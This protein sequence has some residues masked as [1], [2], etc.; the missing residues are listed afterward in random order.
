V[1]LIGKTGRSWSMVI[2]GPIV[3]QMLTVGI[4]YALFV[5]MDDSITMA[6]CAVITAIAGVAGALPITFK[7]IG[8][9]EAAIVA[10]A[11][12]LG[13][14]PNQ[15]LVVAVL[16]RL[17]SLLVGA[18]C[19]G[20]YAAETPAAAVAARTAAVAEPIQELPVPLTI[21]P[22]RVMQ[23]QRSWLSTEILEFTH[24]AII[25]WEMDGAGILYWN[26]AAEQLYGYRREE[27]FGKTT[28]TLLKT[29]IAGGIK[30]LESKIA[31]YGVWVGEL[32][33]VRRDGAQVQVQG[34]L[35]LMSQRG[36]K[37]LVLEVNRDITDLTNAEIAQRSA[38]A[39]LAELRSRTGGTQ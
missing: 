15:A 17:L 2:L 39:Q 14:D 38:E 32:S 36:G 11:A 19:G 33:H 25:I 24:D 29:E 31:R 23:Q 27:V 18:A 1:G 8:A 12:S 21:V 6:Q 9:M 22:Q 16:H 4:L 5:L 3:F 35:A 37:W 7:G 28:H 20:L 26:Q 34:R 10:V 13:I 30:E